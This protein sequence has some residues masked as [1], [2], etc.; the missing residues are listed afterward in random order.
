M[1]AKDPLQEP[2]PDSGPIEDVAYADAMA[3]VAHRYAETEQAGT[4]Y[5]LLAI[6]ARL[7]MVAATIERCA[8]LMQR[9][10]DEPFDQDRT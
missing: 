10:A 1:S 7:R 5:A 6:D 9:A 8:D 2:R 3:N 4:I